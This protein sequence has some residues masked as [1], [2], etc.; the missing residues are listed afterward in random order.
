VFALARMTGV[1]VAS[2]R[3]CSKHQIDFAVQDLKKSQHLI[4]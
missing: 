2:G 1:D 3:L 4:Y